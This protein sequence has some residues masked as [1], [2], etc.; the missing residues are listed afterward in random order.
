MAIASGIDPTTQIYVP[1]NINNQTW[2]N[3]FMDIVLKPVE[4]QGIDFWW[5]DW[6]QWTSG[7]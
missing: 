4:E 1:F 5:L 3:N 7:K 2:T 6:Q